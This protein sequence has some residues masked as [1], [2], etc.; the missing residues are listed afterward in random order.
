MKT[1]EVVVQRA[2]IP[3]SFSDVVR[4]IVGLA[5]LAEAEDVLQG[6][7]EEWADVDRILKNSGCK[8]TG[9]TSTQLRRLLESQPYDILVKLRMLVDISQDLDFDPITYGEQTPEIIAKIVDSLCQSGKLQD[10]LSRGIHLAKKRG[11]NV[12]ANWVYP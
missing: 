11:A 5:E 4:K 1:L 7:D 2:C 3:N 12:E 8:D 10:H 9:R 6:T